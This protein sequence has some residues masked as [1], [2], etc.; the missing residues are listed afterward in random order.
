MTW[1]HGAGYRAAD[2]HV[3]LNGPVAQVQRCEMKLDLVAAIADAIGRIQSVADSVNDVEHPPRQINHRRAID[4]DACAQCWRWHGWQRA[5]PHEPLRRTWS[6]LFVEIPGAD[7]VVRGGC[8]H[9]VLP[10]DGVN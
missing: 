6:M 1:R 2:N 9:Q 8:D 4:S 5:R 7:L 3:A 10:G